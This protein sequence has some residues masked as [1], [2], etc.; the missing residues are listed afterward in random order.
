MGTMV[1]GIVANT[2]V[3]DD[4]IKSD[5]STTGFKGVSAN[6]DKF[7]AKCD[8]APCHANYLGNF[9]TPEEAAQAYL[10][11]GQIHPAQAHLL[12][13]KKIRPEKKKKKKNLSNLQQQIKN[14]GTRLVAAYVATHSKVAILP[15]PLR[16]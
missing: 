5:R 12:Q 11:H 3:V 10:L 13:K 9:G 7:T 14:V 8:T 6:K 15:P 2:I 1:D 16:K 4:L